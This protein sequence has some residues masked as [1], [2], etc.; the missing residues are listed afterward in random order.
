MLY[1]QGEHM[2]DSVWDNPEL[3]FPIHSH[4]GPTL[5]ASKSSDGFRLPKWENQTLILEVQIKVIL[6]ASLSLS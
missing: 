3:P 4:K 1:G 6:C 2:P 5:K